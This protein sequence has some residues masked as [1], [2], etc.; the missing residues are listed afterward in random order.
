MRD[1]LTILAAL[2]IFCLSIALAG[3]YFVDWNAQRAFIETQL[4]QALG[5]KLTIRGNID[6]KLL[7]TPYLHLENIEMQDPTGPSFS[8]S[9]VFLEIAIPPLLRGDI[10]FIQAHFKSPQLKL[11]QSPDGT[12]ALPQPKDFSAQARFERIVFEDGRIEIDD[13][14][15]S[16]TVVLD[17]FNLD[18]EAESLTGPFK[19]E[20]DAL[21]ARELTRFHFSTG[22]RDGDAMR[23]K[24]IVEKS[25]T[26]PRTDLDGTL[27]FAK[28]ADRTAMAFTGNAVFSGIWQPDSDQPDIAIPWRLNG[29]LHI[30]SQKA[31][32]EALELRLG[33][34]DHAVSGSGTAEIDFTSAPKANVDLQARQVD[35]E[36]FLTAQTSLSDPGQIEHYALALANNPTLFDGA[37]SLHLTASAQTMTLNGETLSDLSGAFVS[38]PGDSPWVR[39]ESS[40]PGRSHVYL[41]G[42]LSTGAEPEFD[43]RIEAGTSD[44][45]RLTNWLSPLLPTT[46]AA[47]RKLPFRAIDFS[48]AASFSRA[49]SSGYGLKLQFDQTALSGDVSYQHQTDHAPARLSADLSAPAL[50][51]DNLPNISSLDALSA[52][53]DLSIHIKA[54]ATKI[55]G[56]RKGTSEGGDAEVQL[57]RSGA[58]TSLNSLTL[59]GIGGTNLSAKGDWNGR[60]G[61]IDAKL[62]APQLA[63]LSRLLHQMAPDLPLEVLDQRARFL[64][65]TTLEL[66][67]EL[68][69]PSQPSRPP[70]LTTLALKGTAAATRFVANVTPQTASATLDTQ[71][72]NALLAQLGLDSIKLNSLG[73]GHIDVKSTWSLASSKDV[74]IQATFGGTAFNFN[75]HVTQPD[76]LDVAGLSAQGLVTLAGADLTPLLQT[77]GLAFPDLTS[78]L[79]A[80]LAADLTWSDTRLDLRNVTGRFADIPLKGHLTYSPSSDKK[81][82][83][84]IELDHASAGGL[85]GL[86]MGPPQPVK[87][88]ALWSSLSF[89]SG[90]IDP[91]PTSITLKAKSFDLL[92]GLSGQDAALQF[93]TTPGVFT[94]RDLTM[95]LGKGTTAGTITL[96]RYGAMAALSGHLALNGYDITL[97]SL[98]A[99]ASLDLDL[100]GSG[101][102]A[103]TLVSSLAGDG[104]ASL[105]DITIPRADAGAMERVF[106]DVEHDKLSIDESEIN[107][108]LIREFDHGALKIG[109]RPFDLSLTA[110]VLRLTP[111]SVDDADNVPSDEMSLSLD[112]RSAS[113][114]QRL[115]LSLLALPKDWQGPPPRLS[116]IFKGPLTGPQRTIEAA[117]FINAMAARSIAREAARIQA[118]EFDVHERMVFNQR[119]QLERRH[120]QERLAAEEDAR[121]SAE[122]ARK[123]EEARKRLDEPIH[124]PSPDPPQRTTPP[125]SNAFQPQHSDAPADPST[126]ERY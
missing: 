84:A 101:K 11:L 37:I 12:F 95:K 28:K 83:G 17:Q 13:A 18:A 120:D 75:G 39:F 102:T 16:T 116:L 23:L 19:G 73:H 66:H 104:H 4:S 67:A 40:L 35:L 56:S 106:S 38:S 53:L 61:N 111:T 123:A 31:E 25:K 71:D 105:S 112:L 2:L 14:A 34:E 82:T 6:L 70:S 94:F 113:L 103:L 45:D 69:R 22:V 124:P 109:T 62:S 72:S 20:G 44:L 3:P 52:G 117:G 114:E 74:G 42:H 119:L 48:G 89:A 64:S 115:G 108:A 8:A 43:G 10:D 41:D 87:A 27:S 107:R 9:D 90:L 65:P 80:E 26:H 96:R 79:P 50:D 121:R 68:T 92:P 86:A 47:L 100:A 33:D 1:S 58:N 24:L 7:P 21:I 57:I 91:P 51:I 36:P 54:H 88:N 78:H 76:A 46:S 49:A 59:S 99:T 122:A 15:Q 77:A 118:Y 125:V 5:E 81:I 60:T 85:I 93:E 55:A 29:P 97:P 98:H 32:M 30:A 126:A 63:E 110:G